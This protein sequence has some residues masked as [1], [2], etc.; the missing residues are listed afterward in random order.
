MARFRM[1]RAKL[2]TLQEQHR[3]APK[4]KRRRKGASA[5]FSCP[6]CG[7]ILGGKAPTVGEAR[8]LAKAKK[9]AHRCADTTCLAR[10]RSRG[11][12]SSGGGR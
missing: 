3:D 5:Y 1:S 4:V 11:R 12:R 10:G 8:E 7:E 2:R 9:E 6:T